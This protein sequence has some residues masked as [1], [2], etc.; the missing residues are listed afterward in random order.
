[1]IKIIY[2]ELRCPSMTW[3]YWK[4]RIWP[5]LSKKTTCYSTLNLQLYNFKTLKHCNLTTLKPYNKKTKRQKDKKTKTQKDKKTKWQNDKMTKD[6]ETIQV[7]SPHY[8]TS[9]VWKTMTKTI[10]QTC[11][12]W[13]TD[14]NSDNWEP[15]K[16]RFKSEVDTD[17]VSVFL[18][19]Q[20]WLVGW[21]SCS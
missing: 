14:Y 2:F 11:D 9:K 19:R 17:G 16:I 5:L 20:G 18:A 6:K 4:I 12:I 8:I 1:M 3:S 15:R 7:S 13:D 10:L 21:R